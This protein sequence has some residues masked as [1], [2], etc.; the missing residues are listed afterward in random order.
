MQ[1]DQPEEKR[2]TEQTDKS[3]SE[4]NSGEKSD[5]DMLEGEDTIAARV[6]R[7]HQRES[8]GEEDS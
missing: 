8:N 6:R 7:R 5:E 3:P 4:S 1:D 2:D